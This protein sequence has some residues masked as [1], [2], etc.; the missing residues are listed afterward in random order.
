MGTKEIPGEFNCYANAEPNEPMFVLLA[1]DKHAPILVSLWAA[2][3]ELEGEDYKKVSEAR[4]LS[5]EMT[6]WRRNRKRAEKIK[7]VSDMDK[8]LEDL[9]AK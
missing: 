5:I 4:S 8:T 2:L 7:A 9:A 1:R 3:R 6:R